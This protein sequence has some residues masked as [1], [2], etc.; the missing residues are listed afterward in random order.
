MKKIIDEDQEIELKLARLW[1]M[2]GNTPMLGIRY[3][4]KG[5]VRAVY[6]KCEHYKPDGQYQGPDGALHFTTSL[7]GR[8]NST[9]RPDRGGQ[10]RQHPGSH[11]PRSVRPWV[12]PSRSSCPTG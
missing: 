3:R 7:C 9:G 6:A 2:V 4:Y 8:K 12:I 10:Q 11:S 5:T 1:T